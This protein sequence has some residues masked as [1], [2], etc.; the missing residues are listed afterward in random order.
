MAA[1]RVNGL[2]DVVCISQR[3]QALGLELFTLVGVNPKKKALI[4]VKSAQHFHAAFGPIASKVLYSETQGP[5]TQ[6]Y[7]THPYTRVKRPIYPLDK[8]AGAGRLVI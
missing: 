8:D 2:V 4:V 5:S 7:E 1:L 6:R 3:T